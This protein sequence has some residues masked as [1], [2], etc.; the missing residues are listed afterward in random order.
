MESSEGSN[1]DSP[2][3]SNKMAGSQPSP[4]DVT[5]KKK[6]MEAFKELL[7][8][9]NVPSNATWEQ[10]LRLISS[11][12]RYAQLKHLNEKKQAFNAYKVQKQK[13]D[14]EE[15]RRKIKQNKEDLEKFLT[16][17]EYMNSTI[18]YIKAEKLFGHLSVWLNVAER[19]RRDLY[20]DVVTMLEKKE[21]EDAKNLRKRN[22]KVLKD[23]LESM[24]K[25]TYK[26]RWS[27]AQK[28]LFKNPYF[29][30][31]ID[32]QNMD[33]EDALIVFEDHIRTLEKEHAEDMEKKKKW[34][35]RQERKNREAFL[36]LLDEL[37]EIGKLNSTSYWNE[38][39]SIISADERFSHM[40]CQQGRNSHNRIKK[41]KSF[42]FKVLRPWTC[43]NFTWTT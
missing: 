19:D 7:R 42:E 30:K 26:T 43:S 33:K 41:F 31:D 6:A 28:L 32:L 16:S 10:A 9:K 24:Q 15:E 21:K 20:Q 40:L 39:Y 22:I 3:A 17:C 11:D 37:R 38:L 5:D 29:T 12:P 2:K 34:Q 25:V 27:E 8:E 14:K 18:K 13:E 35:R 1:L 4:V 23:I 36:S